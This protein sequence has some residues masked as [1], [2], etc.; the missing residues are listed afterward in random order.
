MAAQDDNRCAMMTTGKLA[1]MIC[2]TALLLAGCV[3][4]PEEGPPPNAPQPGDLIAGPTN[5]SLIEREPDLCKAADYQQYLG[6][7]GTVVSTLFI[8]RDYRVV[9]FAG[10]VSQEYNAGRLNFWLAETGEITRIGCG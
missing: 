4:L 7:P 8:S 2:A 10:I 9:P 5:G 6:Q 3:P 1:T